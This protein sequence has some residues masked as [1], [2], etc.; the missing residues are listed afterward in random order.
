MS[1]GTTRSDHLS[2]SQQ[3]APPRFTALLWGLLGLCIWSGS[4]V[5]T[6]FGVKSSLT[7]YDI[8]ALRFSTG[9]L[10]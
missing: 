3:A 2:L 9:G 7:A 4:F 1:A 10:L 8:I 6:R 5:L